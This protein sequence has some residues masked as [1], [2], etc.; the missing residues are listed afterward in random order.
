MVGHPNYGQRCAGEL[1]LPRVPKYGHIPE[2]L[3]KISKALLQN[4]MQKLLFL[5]KILT[6]S[7]EK[8]PN[9]TVSKTYFLNFFKE[10]K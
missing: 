7:L 3:L 9:S 10:F 1:F 4:I 8:F 2:T 6:N 5:I